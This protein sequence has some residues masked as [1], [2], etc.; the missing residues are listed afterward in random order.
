MPKISVIMTACNSQDFIAEAIESVIKQSFSDWELIVVDDCSVDSTVQ[1]AE[2][3]AKKDSRINVVKMPYNTGSPIIPRNTAIGVAKGEYI[4]PLDSDDKITFDCLERMIMAME[5]GLGDVIYSEVEF[6]GEKSGKLDVPLPTYANMYKFNCVV[7]SAL[8][9][10]SDFDKYGGYDVNMQDGYEDWDFWLNFIDD[11]KL[12]YRI[13]DVLFFY[14]IKNVTRNNIDAKKQ[15]KLYKYV[16]QK[17]PNNIRCVK[18]AWYNK[19]RLLLIHLFRSRKTYA[20]YKEKFQKPMYPIISEPKLIMTLLV[21][22]EES[23]IRE[24]IEFHKSMGVDGFIV[25]DNDSTD[26]TCEILKEYKNRGWVLEI[27]NEPAQDYSQADW[28]HRMAMLAKNKYKADW[29]INADADEFWCSRSG[30]L[31]NEISESSANMLHVPIFNMLDMNGKWQ[32]NIY[33][34]VSELPDADAKKLIQENKLCRF[35]QFSRQIPKVLVR[36]SDYV[37]IHMGNHNA[38]M[39]FRHKNIISKD[40]MI[41]HFNSRG[42]EQFKTKMINGGAAFERNQKLGKDMGAHWRYFYNGFKD[43]TLNIELEYEKSIGAKCKDKIEHLLKEDC[44]IRDFC[45]LFDIEKQFPKIMSFE[46]MLDRLLSGASLARFGDA[47]FDIAMQ[48]NKEDPYQKPSDKLSKRLLDVLH[49][50][51]DD[52]LLVCIPPFNSL[53]NNI[54]NFKDGL[55]FWRWYWRERWDVLSPLFVNKEYGNSFFS[56]DAVFYK[57]DLD[58]IKKIWDNRDVVFVVPENGR[59]EYDDRIFGNIKSRTQVS[60]PA[61][62]AF[63]EYDAILKK[64]K[65][66]NKKTLFFIAAGPTATVLVMDLFKNGYQALDM[67]HFTNCYRQYLGEAKQ[68]EAYPMKRG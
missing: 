60:V 30:S 38:D 3:Y 39:V 21:K 43:G 36:A 44:F 12:F 40:I 35:N 49:Y 33:R 37:H 22:N 11:N 34:I 42:F 6:F 20:G 27:I 51:T 18:V 5:M 15:K 57:L 17:H 58:S 7:N 48:K 23:I 55:S 63:D 2:Q 65:T 32:N 28:V 68:P 31:K 14:R 52:K 64:C 41:Y 53:H 59:F 24:N 50:P 61:T 1:I 56:R 67:G 10:K 16:A 29:I 45:K 13:P 8:Y 62:N 46:S 54:Q 19:L 25:T 26:N 66:Y 4:F 9:K 47:E